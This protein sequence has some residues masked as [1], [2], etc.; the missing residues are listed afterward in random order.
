M[1]KTSPYIE[2]IL[3]N[4]KGVSSWSAVLAMSLGAFALVSSEFMPVSLLTPVAKALQ[5]SEG[6]AG[7]AISISGVFAVLTSLLMLLLRKASTV[8]VFYSA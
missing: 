7:Q 8:K 5:I 1:N 6:Q 3:N 4:K 2:N